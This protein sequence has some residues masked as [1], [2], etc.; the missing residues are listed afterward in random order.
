MRRYAALLCGI[1]FLAGCAAPGPTPVYVDVS[2]LLP[3]EVFKPPRPLATK[4]G[5]VVPSTRAIA[6]TP[7]TNL[8]LGRNQ[9]RLN[10]ALAALEKNRQWAHQRLLGRL[11]QQAE[12][13]VSRQERERL[14][15]INALRA[16]E[17]DAAFAEVRAI[18]ERYA[19]E[20]G[21]DQ[22]RLTSIVTFPDPDPNSRIEI[23]PDRP[24]TAKR[25]K[26]AAELRQQIG[27]L[28]AE[29]RKEVKGLLDQ[30]D[31]KYDK[32][33]S[34][35]KAD[36]VKLMDQLIQQAEADARRLTLGETNGLQASVHQWNVK[37]PAVPGETARIAPVTAV[38]EEP[39]VPIATTAQAEREKLAADLKLWAGEKGYT[40]TNDRVAGTNMT[41]S[42]MR[43]RAA[44]K[45]GLSK[46]LQPKSAGP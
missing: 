42:F 3:R 5:V 27:L 37:L 7:A 32:E 21:L 26:E 15:R 4:V 38:V 25:L 40:L 22:F 23:P 35:L 31:F 24:S 11:K 30:P 33:L 17:L 16:R 13:E 18:F 10:D 39:N 20:I 29:Y 44:W 1:L 28:S 36:M 41:R 8:F 9:A 19:Y 14:D 6:A 34:A 12:N 46:N 43:W 2:A 45:D